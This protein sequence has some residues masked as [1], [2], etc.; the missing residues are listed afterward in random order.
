MMRSLVGLALVCVMATAITSCREETKVDVVG[1]LH[2]D[3][4]PTMTT[5]N[6]S[7]MISDSGVTQYRIVAPLWEV[8]DEGD[9]PHWRFPEGL[10]LRK[11]DRKFRVI[12]TI[13]ADSAIYFKNK[14]LWRLDGHVEVTKEPREVFLSQQV[15]WDQN[16]GIV[17]GD[18]F[19]HIENATH[20]MEGYGFRAKQDFTEYS[21]NHPM[22][23]FPAERDNLK[24]GSQG[25]AQ[26]QRV[27]PAPASSAAMASVPAP[28]S[29]SRHETEARPESSRNSVVPPGMAAP[30]APV[31][32]TTM[33][34]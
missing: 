9:A 2:P 16:K 11:Y 5:R 31:S 30:S 4:M 15:F 3:R 19:I 32:R 33:T 25:G 28:R 1:G 7:T 17:Y 22:G 27:A 23:I 34:E 13:A 29:E 6:V 26:P 8:Y 20:M 24:G 18:S 12:A 21:I 10:Y 14:N